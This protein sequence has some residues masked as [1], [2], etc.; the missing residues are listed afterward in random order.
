MTYIQHI[1]Q[2]TGRAERVAR[3]S[4][5]DSIQA[6]AADYLDRAVAAD[7]DGDLPALVGDSLALSA[8]PSGRCILLAIQRGEH[9]EARIGVA[10]HARC[11]VRLWQILTDVQPLCPLFGDRPSPP[12]SAVQI[13]PQ[14]QN[15]DWIRE[16]GPA[17]AWAWLDRVRD[18]TEA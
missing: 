11:A 5:P 2:S 8:I 3:C 12:W 16:L 10:A 9:I 18:G 1:D 7:R 15:R 14:A 6:C 13:A 17:L 4:V